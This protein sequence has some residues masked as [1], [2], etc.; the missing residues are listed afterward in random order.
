MI[1]FTVVLPYILLQHAL[2]AGFFPLSE[3]SIRASAHSWLG[4]VFPSTER[5]CSD[6]A[7]PGSYWPEGLLASAQGPWGP[8][9]SQGPRWTL[10]PLPV[11]LGASR[12]PSPF[13]SSSF[14]LMQFYS[15]GCMYSLMS[16]SWHVY[17]CIILLYAVER[18]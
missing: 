10:I 6:G 8:R 15:F 17:G 3:I 18:V 7:R 4:F 9:R 14:V 11:R 1:S 16:D 12:W 5:R 2:H 13:G